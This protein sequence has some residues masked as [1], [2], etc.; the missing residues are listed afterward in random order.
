MV[1][2]RMKCQEE[3]EKRFIYLFFQETL[4]QL[5][6]ITLCVY[7]PLYIYVAQA[8]DSYLFI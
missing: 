4:T 5:Y 3:S 1:Y 7:K 8:M 6:L 2:I